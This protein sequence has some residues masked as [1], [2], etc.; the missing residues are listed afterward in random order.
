MG[1]T[2]NSGLIRPCNRLL[3]IGDIQRMFRM[4]GFRKPKM[5]NGRWLRP[6]NSFDRRS[7]IQMTAVC[8]P[9]SNNAVCPSCALG[10]DR[11]IV[12]AHGDYRFAHQ[13]GIG[14]APCEY[15]GDLKCPKPQGARTPF[16][17]LDR[18]VILDFGRF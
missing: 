17:P 8:S 15:I 18:W 10:Q 2:V 3:G 5:E 1:F 12:R 13:V 9:C 16:A 11:V 7:T 14:F 6:E 4:S